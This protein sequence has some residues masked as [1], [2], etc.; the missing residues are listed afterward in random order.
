MTAQTDTFRIDC[1]SCPIRHRAVC[2]RCDDGELSELD[3]VKSYKTYTAGQ[4][5]AIRGETL[6]FVGSIVAGTATLTRSIEDGRT[7]MV[8]LMLPSDFIGRPGRTQVPYDVTAVTDV[9]LCRFRREPF[10]KLMR[11]MPHVQERL[12]EMALD[13]LD[14]ARDWMLLLGRK[15]ARERIASLIA[16]ILKRSNLPASLQD[17]GVRIEL[18]IT[19]EAMANYLGLTIETVSRQ[20]T[21][22]KADGVIEIEGKRGIR[23]PDVEALIAETGEDDDGGVLF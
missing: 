23:I 20:L 10:E 3:K 9:T 6:D 13:E 15:T 4:V 18:P 22:L 16:L 7:Q 11:E 2:A 17:E 21:G 12:L 5:I 1:Q 14:S 8:G 19:R